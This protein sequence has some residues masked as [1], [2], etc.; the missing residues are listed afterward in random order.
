MKKLI[1]ILLACLLLASAAQAAEWAEGRSAAQPYEGVPEVDL[2]KTMGYIMLYPRTKVPAHNFC[3][4]LVI[5]LPREDV[6]LNEG[7]LTLYAGEDELVGAYEFSDTEHVQLRPMDDLE[8]ENMMWGG[9]TCIMVRLDKS[10]KLGESYYVF[11]DEGCFTAADGA[12]RSL[13]VNNPEAWTPLV[14]GDYGV[15]ELYYREPPASA[16]QDAEEA[17]DAAEEE[18]P[19]GSGDDEEPEP[20]DTPEPE[21]EAEEPEEIVY[22]LTPEVG[23]LV[24]FDL[25]IGGDVTSAVVYS[26][27]DSVTFDE[28]QYT[29]SCTVT[30]TV[31][32]TNL[33]LGV[34][35]L[36]GSDVVNVITLAVADLSN[37]PEEAPPEDQ[38]FTTPEPTLEPTPE[39]TPE[40][41]EV[42]AEPEAEPDVEQQAEEEETEAPADEEEP[43]A[44][45]DEALGAPV[46]APTETP[47]EEPTE[48]PEE[49]QPDETQEAAPVEEQPAASGE[50]TYEYAFVNEQD[51]Y[52]LY[53]VF[54][55]DGGIV[56]N[57]STSSP[58]VLVGTFAG[59]LN[60][61]VTI[62]YSGAFQET[63]K[64]K[65]AG[66]PSVGVLID[67]NGFETE[68][69]EVDVSDAVAILSQDGYEDMAL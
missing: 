21:P 68:Y 53:Y 19:S 63:F 42:E 50:A 4:V 52:A 36:N 28:P 20:T 46:E 61:G 12:I 30:G 47:T 10:L 67:G 34:A 39:P 45:V 11:M 6:A 44:G 37:L 56:R 55:I 9:G 16:A 62:N 59:D 35:F 31:T 24:T 60:S 13:H 3:D 65:N 33:D 43:A 54:D 29:Q 38:D 5:Y 23:D 64:L 40:P 17:G 8:L 7:R 25:V 57:F 41:E 14:D 22:K 48:E 51:G 27:N 49:A 66:D 1:A 2:T 32:D 15:S 58:S 18:I 26:E 69:A